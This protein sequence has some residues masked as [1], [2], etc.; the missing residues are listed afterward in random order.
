MDFHGINTVG[1]IWIERVTTKPTIPPGST[2]YDGR[3]ILALDTGFLSFGVAGVWIDIA[4]ASGVDVT[5]NPNPQI[6]I[7]TGAIA[8]I[9][10]N[11]PVWQA[12]VIPVGSI[13]LIDSATQLIGWSLVPGNYDHVIYIDSAAN[14]GVKPSSTWTQTPHSHGSGNQTD[15]HTLTIAEMPSH[16]HPPKAGVANFMSSTGS[17][18][19]EGGDSYGVHTSTGN[20]GGGGGHRHGI[21][22]SS[23]GSSWRPLGYNVTRQSKNAYL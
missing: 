19:G 3:L 21:P 1:K 18:H 2:D 22:S 9:N 12:E 10:A 7:N 6:A 15:S 20:T 17:S 5:S 13:F 14:N 23:G 16:S 8:T 4:D 11:I